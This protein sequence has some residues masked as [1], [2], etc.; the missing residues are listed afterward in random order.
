MWIN[1][2]PREEAEGPLRKR[3]DQLADEQGRVDGVLLVHGLHPHTLEGHLG[4]YRNVLH[5][6]KN[7]VPKW[8][9]EV[10]GILVSRING[11]DYCVRHHSQGLARLLEDDAWAHRLLQ[12]LD[13]PERSEIF[14]VR[15][16]AALAYARG[17]T[18]APASVG[19]SD[20]AAMRDAGW[21]DH[22]ILEINQVASYFAYANRT[23]L[24]LGVELE[25]WRR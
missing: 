5:H 1:H 21:S 14:N 9:L 7:E 18:E 8:F 16:K 4:L 2:I 10:I 12:A 15:D 24:G 3:L 11:C 17:L 6:P 23:V 22:H 25:E 13:D 20:V 19:E